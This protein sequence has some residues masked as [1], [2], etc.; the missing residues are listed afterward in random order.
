MHSVIPLFA[1]VWT[2]EGD[3]TAIEYLRCQQSIRLELLHRLTSLRALAL[4]TFPAE[5]HDQLGLAPRL[6]QASFDA[7]HQQQPPNIDD[8]VPDTA[9]C[10]QQNEPELDRPS[11]DQPTSEA[12]SSS[13]AYGLHDH[14]SQ[15]D[16][17]DHQSYPSTLDAV[18]AGG[19]P[20]DIHDHQHQHH[21]ESNFAHDH[22]GS[23]NHL[24]DQHLHTESPLADYLTGDPQQS[25]LVSNSTATR[26]RQAN[27][28]IYNPTAAGVRQSSDFVNWEGEWNPREAKVDANGT[29]VE[30]EPFP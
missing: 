29:L 20:N 10:Y 22:A 26:N 25:D 24:Y 4:S 23:Q 8:S 1:W 15:H 21:E 5:Q 11:K 13:L 28:S 18:L 16:E 17:Q 9:N 30:V 27:A 3:H 6:V 12:H 7:H 2:D 19:F 14:S